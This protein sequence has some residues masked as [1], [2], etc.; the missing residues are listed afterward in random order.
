MALNAARSGHQYPAYLYEVSREKVREYAHATF[1]DDALYNSDG[2]DAPEED[3]PAPPTFAACITGRVIPMVVDDPE[4]GAHWNLL[5]TNQSFEF[6]RAVRVGDVLTCVPSI[7]D[8]TSRRSM[9]LLTVRV[10]VRQARDDEQVLT[11]TS[12]LAFFAAREG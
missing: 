3:V 5:H 11:A 1:V 12:T 8:I 2:L 10:D 4:L 7:A 6:A 9:E